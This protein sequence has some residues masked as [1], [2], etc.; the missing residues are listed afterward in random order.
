MG[1]VL[2]NTKAT[3]MTDDEFAKFCSENSIYRIERDHEHNIFVKEPTFTYTGKYNSEIIRQ[4]SNWNHENKAG[5]VFDSSTGFTLDNTAI[6]SPDASW[7]RKE[8]WDALSERE[9]K[10][11]SP[12]CPDFVIELKSE[13]DSVIELHE[14]MKEWI[15]NGCRLAWLIILEE[16]KAF[17]YKPN[18]NVKTIQEFY[19]KKLSG[20]D[21]LNGFELDLNELKLEE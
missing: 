6:L 14:K 12:L 15:S 8:R 9:K 17:I 21:I 18:E 10:S 1:I 4:L 5:Y 2:K 13:T 19:G 3:E 7:I 16:E 20:E 11:Y